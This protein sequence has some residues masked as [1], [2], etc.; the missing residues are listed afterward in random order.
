LSGKAMLPDSC[1][2]PIWDNSTEPDRTRPVDNG[3]ADRSAQLQRITAS[4]TFCARELSPRPGPRHRSR[5]SALRQPYSPSE[6][7]R[8]RPGLATDRHPRTACP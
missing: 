7:F 2:R 8:L 1:N 6:I 4:V 5:S 3:Q